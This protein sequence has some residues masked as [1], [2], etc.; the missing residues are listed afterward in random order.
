MPRWMVNLKENIGHVELISIM[1]VL[2][3]VVWKLYQMRYWDYNSELDLSF[4]VEL[5]DTRDRRFVIMT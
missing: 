2:I 3:V 1:P 4:S 5:Y